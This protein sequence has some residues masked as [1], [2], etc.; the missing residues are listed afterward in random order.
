MIVYHNKNCVVMATVDAKKEIVMLSVGLEINKYGLPAYT[1]KYSV[2][3][4]E[5]IDAEIAKNT[6]ELKIQE[7]VAERNNEIS[8]LSDTEKAKLIIDE[9]NSY[10]DQI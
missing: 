2:P 9:L 8:T 7:A 6:I 5:F 10:Y 4:A 1:K 3:A